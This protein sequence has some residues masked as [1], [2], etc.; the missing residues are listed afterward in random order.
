MGSG[1]GPL[2]EAGLRAAAAHARE[3]WRAEEQHWSSAALEQ[4]RH[5]RTLVD[6]ARDHLYRGDTIALRWPG[7]A[8]VVTGRVIGVSDDAIAVATYAGR[9]D[10]ALAP[11]T[12]ISW[13]IVESAARGGSR[14]IAPLTFRARLL[15]LE[16]LTCEVDV[17]HLDGEMVR[18]TLC[19]G[20][21]HVQVVAPGATWVIALSALRWVRE[22]SPA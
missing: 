5:T 16:S 11:G 6:L 4:W 13:R 8:A 21:D 12:A 22:S 7:E 9:V 15:E 3:E 18:G 20:H 14:G 2:D 19:V 10:V 1:V 17:A